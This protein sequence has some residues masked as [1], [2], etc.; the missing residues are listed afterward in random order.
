MRRVQKDCDDLV[1]KKDAGIAKLIDQ[2]TEIRVV[3]E[4]EKKKV[5]Q[6]QKEADERVL[7]EVERT[8]VAR[9]KTTEAN[10]EIDTHLKKIGELE[11]QI[12]R[13]INKDAGYDPEADKKQA[14]E[15]QAAEYDKQL[16]AKDAG[17]DKL[18]TDFNVMQRLKTKE[19]EELRMNAATIRTQIEDELKIAKTELLAKETLLED[20]LKEGE[21]DRASWMEKYERLEA[22]EFTARKEFKARIM[23]LEEE[24]D[25]AKKKSLSSWGVIIFK[26]ITT[27]VFF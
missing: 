15:R 2:N 19:M 3:L 16:A 4:A 12:D 27:Y 10:R 20:A 14:L 1:E 26:P 11:F 18:I 25:V 23:E 21:E 13:I 8:K 6:V 17:Y 24:R 9:Q 7:V 22:M 5:V